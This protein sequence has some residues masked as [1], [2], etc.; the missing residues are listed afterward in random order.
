MIVHYYLLYSRSFCAQ[1]VAELAKK[2]VE[3]E[4]KA[5]WLFE[6]AAEEGRQRE[7]RMTEGERKQLERYLAG[8]ERLS[9]Q[10]EEWHG[11]FGFIR[12]SQPPFLLQYFYENVIAFSCRILVPI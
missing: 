8:E 12:N 4:E 5:R 6:R 7:L 10:L 3:E 11:T 1:Q 2:R 9:G